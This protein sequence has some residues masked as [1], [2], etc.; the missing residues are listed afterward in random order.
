MT[1]LL[2]KKHRI[3]ERGLMEFRPFGTDPNGEKIRDITGVA[4]RANLEYL[5]EVVTRSRGS[6]A[7]KQAVEDLVRRINQ[8]IPDR[9]YHVT[10]EFLMN[11]W[12]SYSYEFLMFLDCIC[13]DL[14]GDQ[15]LQ[16]HMA[17]EKFISPIIQALARPFSVSQIF[18]MWPYFGEKYA[19]AIRFEAVEVGANRANLRISFHDR[20]YREWGPY[21]RSCAYQVCQ[22]TKGAIMATPERIHGLK[23]A[24]IKD[25]QCIA[26]DDPYCQWEVTWEPHSR[27]WVLWATGAV[28]V[29]VGL[30]AAFRV[31]YPMLALFETAL[32]AAFPA[33]AL[34]LA[35]TRRALRAEVGE[36]ERVIHEQ[37]SSV[38][39]RHEELREAYLE[40]QETAAELRRK[41]GQL[42]LLHHTGLIV[43]STLDR[44]ALIHTILEHTK[45]D[46]N[47]DRV[48]MSF[49]DSDR[50]ISHDGRIMGVSQEIADYVRSV[51]I[52]VFDSETI[53]GRVFRQ[54]QPVLVTDIGEAWD[55][56]HPANQ[57]LATLTQAKSF[58]TVPLKAKDRVIGSLTVDRKEEHVLT[59]DDLD[60]MQTVAGQVAIALDN[61]DAYSEIERLNVGLETKVRE[62]TAALEAANEQLKEMDR[63]KSQFLAHVSHELR[64]P[65]T[66]INGFVENMLGGLAGPLTEKQGQYLSRIKANGAR[67]ARMIADVLDRSRIE[68]KK[69]QLV[70]GE[71]VLSSLVRDVVEQLLPLAQAKSQRLELLSTEDSLRVWADLDKVSQILTNLVDNAIKYTPERGSITVQLTQ[72][73][74]HFAKVSVMDTGEGIPADAIPKLFDPFFR[75]SRHQKSPIKGLGLGLSIV[76]DL[77]E[78]HGGRVS[79]ESQ[80]GRG[81]TFTFTLPLRRALEKRPAPAVPSA[82]KRI[83]VVDD[84][85]DIRELLQDRLT[86]DHFLVS[87]A[88]D[89]RQALEMLGR[90]PFDGLILDINMPDI[91]GLEVLHR[92]RETD[93]TLPVIMI[94]AAGAR[95]RALLAMEAGAQAYLLKPL[96]AEQFRLTIDRW[97]GSDT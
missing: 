28:A 42:T 97:L 34:W 83:L 37:L 66:S 52:E 82:G 40:Q 72:E 47:Y 81:S 38:E 79:V 62:R 33:A 68:A 19:P 1:E 41:V 64:T 59:Q 10:R 91:D 56:L 13:M 26:N 95:E 43:S 70:L 44:E 14:S 20:V 71:V 88:V 22:A 36:R 77:V 15:Q 65:L 18:K 12:N 7:A 6:A 49:Y 25:L 45:Y 27:V 60:L 57:R 51:V 73:G 2:S 53:E 93:P 84:D 46:L 8:R 11:Q 9:T 4:V 92:I 5:E 80:E 21:R 87:T 85:P 54:G 39:S 17:R 23:P 24:R 29:W 89:G 58:I 55:K 31:R 78:L 90:A 76:K 74:A 35:Y 67:L 61:A 30:F 3:V 86:A 69:I 75:T 32:L 48:M 94:T 96:D 63:L 50:K 16:I